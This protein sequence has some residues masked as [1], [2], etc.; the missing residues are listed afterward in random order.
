MLG[1]A[2]IISDPSTLPHDLVEHEREAIVAHFN[3]IPMDAHARSRIFELHLPGRP[4]F[5]IKHGSDVLNEA[6]TQ[7]FF[8]RLPRNDP[9][10]PHIP[11]VFDAFSADDY[12][13]LVMEKILAPTLKDSGISEEEAV[14]HAARAVKWLLDQTPSVPASVFGRI[15]PS[16]DP[17]WHRF[18]KDHEAPRAFD[19]DMLLKYIDKTQLEASFKARSICHSDIRD[20][21][22]LLGEGKTVWIIDFQHVSVLP[23]VF[24]TFAFFNT[25]QRF[26]SAVGGRL[27]YRPSAVSDAIGKAS[28]L[29]RQC[30][31]NAS[32]ARQSSVEISVALRGR[33]SHQG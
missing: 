24:L 21:N 22:F 3:A 2:C 18:F 28:S 8:Y 15:S 6:Y 14:G 29:V 5:I 11:R 26:A 32:L 4:P 23:P 13:F 30:G 7:H 9:L 17:V 31:G 33:L 1:L 20:E 12:C 25:G 27:G 10:D 16:D 19:P